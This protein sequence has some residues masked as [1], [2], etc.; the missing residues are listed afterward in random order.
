MTSIFGAVMNGA[1]KLYGWEMAQAF[2]GYS[3]LYALCLKL[4]SQSLGMRIIE[5]DFIL[6]IL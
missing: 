5:I 3:L 4:L 6:L 1:V 2:Q